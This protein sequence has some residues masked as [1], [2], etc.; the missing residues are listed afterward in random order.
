MATGCTAQARA[1]HDEA[2]PTTREGDPHDVEPHG[3]HTDCRCAWSLLWRCLGAVREG[4]VL[5]AVDLV[6]WSSSAAFI[7]WTSHC[8]QTTSVCSGLLF[9]NEY[10]PL[11]L[12]LCLYGFEDILEHLKTYCR[13]MTHHM[14]FCPVVEVMWRCQW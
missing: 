7:L 11:P 5:S 3:R 13:W 14:V 1:R 8:V 6:Y 10:L 12:L 4:A 2:I 9:H